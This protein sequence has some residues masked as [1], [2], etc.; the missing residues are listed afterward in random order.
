MEKI[1]QKGGIYSCKTTAG[2]FLRWK[3]Q[4][5][6]CIEAFYKKVK[7]KSFAANTDR[8]SSNPGGIAESTL[9]FVFYVVEFFKSSFPDS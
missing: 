7:A 3:G 5:M 4:N 9:L 8:G 6:Q 2:E 1:L